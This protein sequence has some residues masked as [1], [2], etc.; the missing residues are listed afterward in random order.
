MESLPYALPK[1]VN[2]VITRDK[3]YYRSDAIVK[4][5]I[6]DALA[7]AKSQ[8]ETEVFIL[9]GGTIYQQTRHL[10]N[11]LYLT[12]VDASPDGDTY[13]PEIDLSKYKLILEEHNQA[14]EKNI[15]SY[16][17]KIYEK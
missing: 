2:I 16:T 6:D 5:S 17:F 15:Y 7:Y 4:H 11:R 12:E 8:G 13:F 9:G 3:K 1:R 10:W 14:D